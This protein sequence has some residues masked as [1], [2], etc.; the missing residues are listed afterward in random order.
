MPA[1]HSC[2]TSSS[3]ATCQKEV[4]HCHTH[5]MCRGI[6]GTGSPRMTLSLFPG[7]HTCTLAFRNPGTDRPHRA[8]SPTW[9][10]T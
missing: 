4:R 5:A 7:R 8:H 3:W 6:P 2:R 10:D 9:F 1:L